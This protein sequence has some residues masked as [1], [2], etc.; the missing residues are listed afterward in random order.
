MQVVH[1]KLADETGTWVP[2]QPSPNHAGKFA[3]GK[4]QYIIIHYTASASADAA[5]NWFQSARSGV[6][7]HLVVDHSGKIIQMVDL[8]TIAWHAGK[9]EWHGIIGLNSCAIGIEIANWGLL[10]GKQ[11]AWKSWTGT[12][13]ADERVIV[14]RH[15]NFDVNQDHGWEIFDPAQIDAVTRITRA[16]MAAYGLAASHVLGHEEIAPGR[17]QDPGP[18]FDMAKFR[19]T[20]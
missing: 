14:A 15:A 1:S 5:V 4:P 9:S 2:Q 7:A 20:L 8:D 13:I 6:S 18:A 10:Q 19:T 17:K 11:G 12:T 3:A 16:L